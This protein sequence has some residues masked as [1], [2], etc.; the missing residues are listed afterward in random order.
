MRLGK[1]IGLFLAA[2]LCIGIIPVNAFAAGGSGSLENFAEKM[3]CS[4]M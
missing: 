2:V 1:L 3:T 4:A